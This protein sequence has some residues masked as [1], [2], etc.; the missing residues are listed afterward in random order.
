MSAVADLADLLDLLAYPERDSR[1]RLGRVA[2]EIAAAV[3]AGGPPSAAELLADALDA[4]T[5]LPNDV[6][7]LV[8]ALQARRIERRWRAWQQQPHAEWS[9]LRARGRRQGGGDV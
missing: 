2:H 7:N 6:D 3:D 4:P 1:H 5:E 9:P 8:M